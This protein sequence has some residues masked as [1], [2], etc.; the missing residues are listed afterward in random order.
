LLHANGF[1]A[2]HQ[3]K[4]TRISTPISRS[5]LAVINEGK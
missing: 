2:S 4:E 5:Y 1:I 3:K